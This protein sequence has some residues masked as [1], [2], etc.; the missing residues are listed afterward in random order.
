MFKRVAPYIGEYKGCRSDPCCFA[1]T[2]LERDTN[3]YM[4]GER[5]ISEPSEEKLEISSLMR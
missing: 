1:W 5:Y 3:V 2:D 4:E